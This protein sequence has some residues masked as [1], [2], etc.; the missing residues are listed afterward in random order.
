MIG[1]RWLHGSHFNS[2]TRGKHCLCGLFRVRQV[3][4]LPAHTGN[5]CSF[6]SCGPFH[7]SI[8]A[9]TGNMT[10]SAF[11]SSMV[12]FNSRTHGKHPTRT[13]SSPALRFQF[14]HTRETFSM[15]FYNSVATVSIP[16]HTGNIRGHRLRYRAY[17][18]NS[19]THG[20]HF[21]LLCAPTTAYFNSRTHGKHHSEP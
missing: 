6:L 7:I 15:A 2:R 17:V 13:T 21:L 3:V 9:H 20:K 12:L 4:S 5:I 19:R 16:A 11:L 1:T 18:F 8:P 14:P 10:S